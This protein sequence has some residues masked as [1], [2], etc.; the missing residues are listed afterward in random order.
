[1]R[2]NISCGQ[3]PTDRWL[4]ITAPYHFRETTEIQRRLGIFAQTCVS[5]F[6]NIDEQIEQASAAK[7]DILD[8]Y[9]GSILLLAREVERRGLDSIKP[10]II[11]GTAD[12]IDS[13]SMEHIERVFG[14]PFYDQFGCSELDRT[15]WQCPEKTGYHMDVDSVII[16]FV[17]E[18]GHEVS[19]S[20]R[21]EIVYTS[22]FNLAMPFIR[23]AVGD[24]GVPSND[25]CPCG[26]T[27]PL[28]E[29][30]EGR[31]DSMLLLPDGKWLSPRSFT[32]A[33][34]MFKYYRFI[35]RF[36]IIQ[37]RTDVFKIY[38]KNK[39]D[40]IDEDEMKN[41]LETY[42]NKLFNAGKYEL[43]I[44]TICVDDL[45]LDSDGKLKSVTS[46][47]KIQDSSIG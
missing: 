12:L 37:K 10:R 15:A 9:S 7:P 2:A 42:M 47:L 1:M 31:K 25:E 41:E 46:E 43:K 17:D 13:V 38:I 44:E 23:Y 24:V 45:P 3:K 19:P 11:F 26:R 33:L 16:Q 30:I 14:A 21:G 35:E 40:S 5:V 8:G 32:V 22:L 27:L 6:G 18:D 36:R 28:M 34:S 39:H 4:T 29:V 20:E